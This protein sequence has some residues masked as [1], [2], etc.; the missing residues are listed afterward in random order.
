MDFKSV[1]RFSPSASRSWRSVD[2]CFCSESR[3]RPTVS[4]SDVV[5]SRRAEVHIPSP[6]ATRRS[7]AFTAPAK[8][9]TADRCAAVYNGHITG[10]GSR[11]RAIVTI[12]VCTTHSAALRCRLSMHPDVNAWCVVVCTY[13]STH[14]PSTAGLLV[15]GCSAAS[16]Q[17]TAAQAPTQSGTNVYP[18]T[19]I[20]LYPH[21]PY[22]IPHILNPEACFTYIIHSGPGRC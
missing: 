15:A 16:P 6:A 21:T 7:N 18:N 9:S 10:G 20:S 14:P 17:C 5:S 2:T 19:N 3:T 11:V 22:S 12:T 1:S 8:S 13:T 4:A